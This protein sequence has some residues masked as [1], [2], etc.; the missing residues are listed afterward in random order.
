MAASGRDKDRSVTEDTHHA[1]RYESRTRLHAW[2]YARCTGV[3]LLVCLFASPL[4]HAQGLN[5]TITYQASTGRA[6]VVFAVRHVASRTVRPPGRAAP[7]F[8]RPG[9]QQPPNT[10]RHVVQF[11]V[12]SPNYFSTGGGHFG[13]FARGDMYTQTYD[14]SYPYRGHGVILGDVSAYPNFNHPYG[15]PCTPTPAFESAR[16]RGRR[17]VAG[18]VAAELR[19]RAGNLQPAGPQQRCVVS[20]PG[21]CPAT[22]MVSIRPAIRF[23]FRPWSAGWSTRIAR[24]PMPMRRC[25]AI[26]VAGLAAETFKR[27][28]NW[29]LYINNLDSHWE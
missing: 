26:S 22:A 5:Y 14:P 15:Y 13:L 24:R 20:G 19:V 27:S 21:W 10:T 3:L 28:S 18:L 7:D 16:D 1:F 8:H 9:T 25:R 29:T 17:R 11:D 6:T 12:M 2:L 23:I 4:S